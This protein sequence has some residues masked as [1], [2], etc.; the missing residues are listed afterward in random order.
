MSRRQ[1]ARVADDEDE[2]IRRQ[3]PSDRE[4]M[5]SL[6]KFV[7]EMQKSRGR[8]V[9]MRLAVLCAIAVGLRVFYSPR[10]ADSAAAQ[11]IILFI[12]SKP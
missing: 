8:A 5:Q 3:K 1:K 6:R 10:V 12:L 9:E 4:T 2:P 11:S 7:K